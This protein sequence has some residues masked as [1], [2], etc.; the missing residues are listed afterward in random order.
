MSTLLFAICMVIYVGLSVYITLTAALGS[1]GL[2]I[3]L[4]IFFVGA[5]L[6]LMFK[7]THGG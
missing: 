4:T 2:A 1:L 3:I 7:N 6:V 5:P